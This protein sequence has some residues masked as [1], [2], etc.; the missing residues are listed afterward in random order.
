MGKDEKEEFRVVDRRHSSA[1]S[2]TEQPKEKPKSGDGFTMKDAPKKESVP[3]EIDFST[4]VLSLATGAM[5]NMGL[6]PDPTTNKVEKND[7]LAKQN[8]DILALLQEKTKGNLSEA[9]QDLIDNLLTEI[10]IR[11]VQK[12][13]A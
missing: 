2:K 3:S 13:K 5:I 1:E 7:M 6:A 11:F 12:G 9:E 4:F 10:R 8:I